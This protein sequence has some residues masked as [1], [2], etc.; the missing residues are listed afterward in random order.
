M[1]DE[2]KCRLQADCGRYYD[3]ENHA[4]C[5]CYSTE[6]SRVR[7]EQLAGEVR[8]WESYCAALEDVCTPEQLSEA[9]KAARL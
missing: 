7:V 5:W 4:H 1:N 6:K 3:S 8:N 9:R 2:Q